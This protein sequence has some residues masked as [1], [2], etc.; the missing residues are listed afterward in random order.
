MMAE[1]TKCALMHFTHLLHPELVLALISV[2]KLVLLS[3]LGR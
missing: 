3:T 2:L 1:R